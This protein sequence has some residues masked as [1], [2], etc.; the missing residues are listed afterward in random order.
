MLVTPALAEEDD[1]VVQV[2]R[3]TDDTVFICL[4][5]APVCT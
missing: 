2:S 1:F 3:S 4:H 5:H